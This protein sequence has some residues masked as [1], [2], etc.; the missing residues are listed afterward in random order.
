MRDLALLSVSE[1]GRADALTIDGGVPGIELM[2]AAG[3]AVSETVAALCSPAP[4]LLACGP[5][6][7]GGDGFVA[8]RLLAERGWDVTV[9]L[10]GDRAH[11]KGDALRAAERWEGA[12]VPLDPAL[13]DQAGV[14]VD[15]IFGAGLARDIEGPVFD[16]LQ[17]AAALREQG[18]IQI[19]AVDMPSGIDGDSGSVR[20]IAAPA[21]TTVTFFRKK[22]GHL[23]FPGR[24]YSGELVVAEIGVPEGVLEEI[25]PRADENG[26][27]LWAPE[28]P[29]PGAAS[30]KYTRGHALISGGPMTGAG[31]LSARA[32]RRIGAGLLTMAAPP[33]CIDLYAGDSPGVITAAVDDLSAFEAILADRRKNAVLVGPGHGVNER[34][35]SFAIAALEAGKAVVLDA[36]ALTVFA[37]EAQLLAGLISGPT[38]LT[39]HEGEFARLFPSLAGSKLTRASAAARQTGAVVVLKGADTVIAAPD[40][41]SVINSNAPPWLATGGTGDVLAGTVLGLLAQGMP[42]FAA[43]SAAVW[44]NG[45]AAAEFGP[46]LIAEDLP[47][48]FPSVLAAGLQTWPRENNPSPF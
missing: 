40:G 1:M 48:R 7:N 17:A 15:A 37:G 2:E 38:V 34:T 32:A 27:A 42:V 33:R 47:E 21:D 14:L 8:A 10:F 16:F 24:F 22:P 9:A 20:G 29:F 6:N 5:G 12:I 31:R 28:M 23:L 3:L 26:P 46:G 13:L 45:A 11:L 30:H 41:R 25:R 19:V 39:P 35:R 43:A 18:R 4:V 36:D 44:I